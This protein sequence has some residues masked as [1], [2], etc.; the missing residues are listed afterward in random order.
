MQ[1]QLM[2][3]IDLSSLFNWNT[4]Q[5]FVWITA[6]YP[7]SLP[8]APPSQAIIWDSIINSYSQLHPYTP[9]DAWKDLPFVGTIKA[10]A[11]KS[12]SSSKKKAPEPEPEPTPGIIKLKNSKPKYQITDVSGKLASQGNV[13][14]ELGW[15]VQPWV[16]ALTWTAKEGQGFGRWKGLKGGRSEAFHLP[17]LKGKSATQ[18]TVIPKGTPKP[19]EAKP[20]VP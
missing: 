3:L 18:D 19:A 9:F 1:V 8:T 17:A 7:S 13:T 12:K 4:K 16:G 6:T 5:V 11:K 15:N 14:L 2:S 20:V 10:P